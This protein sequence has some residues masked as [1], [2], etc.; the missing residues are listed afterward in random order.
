MKSADRV[1]QG[2]HWKDAHRRVCEV[3][4]M[5]EAETWKAYRGLATNSL[6]I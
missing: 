5:R 3:S 6:C 4:N 2:S 1:I